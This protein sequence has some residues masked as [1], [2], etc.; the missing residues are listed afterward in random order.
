VNVGHQGSAGNAAVTVKVNNDLAGSFQNFG[1][2]SIL[3]DFEN[4]VNQS[5]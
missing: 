3:I 2:K 5:P 1:A 4:H